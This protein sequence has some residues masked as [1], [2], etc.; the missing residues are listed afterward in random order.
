MVRNMFHPRR[1]TVTVND[2][3]T[4]CIKD[5]YANKCHP[6]LPNIKKFWTIF[7]IN[8]R[9]LKTNYFSIFKIGLF[10][11]NGCVLSLFSF[12]AANL[13]NKPFQLTYRFVY[14]WQI[15]SLMCYD[16]NKYE[17]QKL[18]LYKPILKLYNP[19]KLRLPYLM[20]WVIS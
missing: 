10:K 13:T 18:D 17:E 8:Y 19:S 20:H 3:C 9:I 15:S 11:K 4:G 16:Q 2:T 1:Y 5:L 7:D 6:M 12:D 14:N